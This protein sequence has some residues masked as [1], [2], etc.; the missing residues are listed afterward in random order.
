MVI[1]GGGWDEASS[2]MLKHRAVPILGMSLWSLVTTVGLFRLKEWARA[3]ALIIALL[4]LS[5]WVLLPNYVRWRP[6]RVIEGFPFIFIDEVTCG[7]L[8]VFSCWLLFLFNKRSIK[9]LFTEPTTPLQR[10]YSI[11]LL[12]VAYGFA[13]LWKI[14]ILRHSVD[15]AIVFGLPLPEWARLPY[16]IL[17]VLILFYLTVGLWRLRPTARRIAIWFQVY[18]VA[19]V[20][21]SV[22]RLGGL[23]DAGDLL[24]P[25]NIVILWFLIRRKSAF[26]NLKA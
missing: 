6:Y 25:P 19:E 3:S 20:F 4:F 22:M 16:H 11:T 12:T 9:S 13:A 15:S 17:V 26:Q 8:I 10:P 7:T 14:E 21:F 1:V 5:G 23:W 18:W 24:F 2:S